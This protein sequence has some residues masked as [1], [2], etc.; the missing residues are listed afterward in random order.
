MAI[1]AF[2]VL[3]LKKQ[4]SVLFERLESCRNANMF[5]DTCKNLNKSLIEFVPKHLIISHLMNTLMLHNQ[6]EFN[7]KDHLLQ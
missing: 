1:I 2:F 3:E 6:F 7:F 4:Q 5:A